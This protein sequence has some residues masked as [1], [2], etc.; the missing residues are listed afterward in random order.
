MP[1]YFFN[2][3]NDYKIEDTEGTDL[4]DVSSA[5][6]HARTVVRELMRN[7]DGLL[8]K[9]WARWTM[10]VKDGEGRQ[11]L[12]IPLSQDPWSGDASGNGKNHSAEAHWK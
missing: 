1:L 12:S 11:I 6:R 5:R 2:L 4:P 10:L 9:Q 7:S 8:G 3:A